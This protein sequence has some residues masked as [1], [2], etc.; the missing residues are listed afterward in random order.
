MNIRFA[1]EV[2]LFQKTL[3]YWD[4]IIYVMGSNRLKNYKEMCQMHTNG[5]FAKWL[6]K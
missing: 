2:I 1:S 5:K 4:A 3:E 6:L